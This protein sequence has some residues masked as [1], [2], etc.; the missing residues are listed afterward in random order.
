MREPGTIFSYHQLQLLLAGLTREGKS[1]NFSPESLKGY[2]RKP[3]TRQAYRDHLAS[4][5]L[6]DHATV[7]VPWYLAENIDAEFL[8]REGLLEITDRDEVDPI[9]NR[10]AR[11][12]SAC[13]ANSRNLEFNPYS[14]RQIG[15]AHV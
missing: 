10:I 15:R 13:F 14:S 7:P 5:I 8:I 4:L 3:A 2:F 9:K 12:Y 1:E 11:L 6:F